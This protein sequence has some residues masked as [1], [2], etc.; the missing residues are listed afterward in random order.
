MIRLI[1]I[2]SD[3]TVT[4]ITG[5]RLSHENVPLLIPLFRNDTANTSA[6]FVIVEFCKVWLKHWMSCES[7]ILRLGLFLRELLNFSTNSHWQSHKLAPKDT[8]LNLGPIKS[9]TWKSTFSLFPCN[10]RIWRLDTKGLKVDS[11]INSKALLC[12]YSSLRDVSSSNSCPSSNLLRPLSSKCK[13]SNSVKPVIDVF[14]QNI[15]HIL[16][17]NEL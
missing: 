6:Q 1:T 15:I 9:H 14:F 12:R 10:V 7:M 16:L 13:T 5:N 3:A 11:C 17:P 2:I 8:D 4:A